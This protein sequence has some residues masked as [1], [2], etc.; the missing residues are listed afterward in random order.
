MSA[1]R[2]CLLAAAVVGAAFAFEA[3]PATAQD[4]LICRKRDEQGGRQGEVHNLGAGDDFFNAGPGPD[5]VYG[6]PGDD[7]INGG[8]GNDRVYGGPGDD[9]VCGGVGR[10]VAEGED[11][12]DQVFGE[13]GDDQLIG[14]PGDDYVAGQAGKDH[15]I[16]WG[17]S[18]S[19]PVPDGNDILE[20]S[21]RPDIIEL[22]GA[23]TAFGGIDEDVLRSRTPDVGAALMEG[24]YDTDEIY[25]SDAA[26]TITNSKGRDRIEAGGG[27]DVVT[28]SRQGEVIFGGLGD[29]TIR[30][31]SGGDQLHGDEGND[32]CTGIYRAAF[33]R[34]C[35]ESIVINRKD[36]LRPPSEQAAPFAGAAPLYEAAGT[37]GV[38]R[39]ALFQT[40]AFP[41]TRQVLVRYS[42]SVNST[43]VDGYGY[44]SGN[45]FGSNTAWLASNSPLYG[46]SG[47]VDCDATGTWS[48]QFYEPP[49]A[50]VSFP[51]S[52]MPRQETASSLLFR[53]PT[54]GYYTADVLLTQGSVGVELPNRE[55]PSA[56]A[57]G[58]SFSLGV[59]QPGTV[60]RL[61]VVATKVT[62]QARWT[63]TI[64]PG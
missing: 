21:Y 7:I 1:R 9:I 25:G 14:G 63:I 30:G 46:I 28:G 55:F 5:V 11:G 26:D 54:A 10:D 52:G 6:G 34:S 38:Q 50:P 35:E 33:D 39:P 22:G 59:L 44:F 58:G 20:G 17:E 56:D 49:M 40:P 42:T 57:P 37:C 41:S 53:V 2:S 43:E 32:L 16:G 23:D 12:R 36:P 19:G 45:Y 61:G 24:G 4:S 15:L 64:R 31:T 60:Y 51:G 18:P 13:E 47:S 27:N 62:E 3:I 48:L 29:D 8:R